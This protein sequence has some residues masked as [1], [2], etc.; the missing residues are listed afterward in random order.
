MPRSVKAQA[1]AGVFVVLLAILLVLYLVLLPADTRE[2]LL[3][4]SGPDVAP[5]ESVRN[6][7]LSYAPSNDPQEGIRSRSLPV[8]QL[9]TATEGNALAERSSVSVSR[10]VFDSASDT[11]RFSAPDN[12]QS[13]LLSFSVA[14]ANGMIR[15][16][17]NNELIEQTVLD[18]RQPEPIALPAVLLSSDNE[19]RFELAPVGFSFWKTDR[20]ELR[21]VRVTADVDSFERAS[22]TYRFVMSD[23][24]SLQQAQLEFFVDCYRPGGRLEILHNDNMVYS[25]FPT[26][27]IPLSLELAPAQMSESENFLSFSIESGEYLIDQAE[28][29]TVHEPES[30]SSTFTVTQQ[31]L[32]DLRARGSEVF[33]GLS[34]ESAVA[35]GTVVVNNQPLNFRTDKQS[36]A[37][38]I[39]P[40]VVAGQNSVSLRSSN[41]AVTL[42]E[43]FEE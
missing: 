19:L 5:N 27:G 8:V 25:G 36:F 4:G 1:Q 7:L 34:F 33:L 10:S 23:V 14:E 16:Y 32:N 20:Y 3:G 15:I 35:Q 31:Q 13:V 24:A 17:L 43:V 6:V 21:N 2:G 12:A 29:I 26:C 40:Y 38:A 18:R 11:L 9:R 28:L 22:Q 42:I 41:K 39:T 37:S 30:R